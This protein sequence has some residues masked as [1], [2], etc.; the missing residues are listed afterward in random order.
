MSGWKAVALQ[1]VATIEREVVEAT[2]IDD[3][4]P[5]VGLENI[6]S[7]G[8]FINVREVESGELAS[9]KF[10]FTPRHLLYGKLRPYLAKIARPRFGGICSTDILPVLPGANLDRDFLAHFLLRP[11]SIALANSRA[12]GANLP[13]LSPRALADLK[14][15]LPPLPE[16]RRIAAILDKADALRAKRRAALAQLDTLT[17]TIFLGMFGDPAAN[18]KA[19]PR[20]RFNELLA[21]IDSGWSP[22]CL[23]RPVVG[24][25]WGVLKLGAVTSCEYNEAQNKALPP[26]VEP[27]A[28]IEVKPGDLLFARKNTYELVAACALVRET[29]HRLLM[30]DLIFRLRLRPRAAV[31]SCFLHQLLI[32]PTKRRDIQRLAG[33][34]AGSMPNISKARL[35]SIAIEVPPSELQREF[36]RR[37]AVVESQK[38]I[39]RASLSMLEALFATLQHRAFTG[40]LTR[41]DNGAIALAETAE[42]C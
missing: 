13:R 28:S 7:G 18:P 10:S 15:P 3:G 16:Q 9:S 30:S 2:A 1:D 41:S 29:R 22:N 37:I 23:D 33:G 32:Y 8:N 6:E 21:N 5:Y 14:L 36:R 40:D 34:S 42:P 25:E 19:W 27:D 17:Q 20:V 4:T 24:Q 12:T 31:D 11:E 39:Q 35:G 38:S 26:E